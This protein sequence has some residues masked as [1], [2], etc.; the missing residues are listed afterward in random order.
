VRTLEKEVVD[1]H[2]TNFLLRILPYEIEHS[3]IDGAVITLVE[4]PAR[5]SAARVENNG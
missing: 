5:A 1:R 3:R 2:G 4:I